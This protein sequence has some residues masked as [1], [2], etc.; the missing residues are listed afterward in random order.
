MEQAKLS[1]KFLS[2]LTEKYPN[3][4][5]LAEKLADLLMIEKVSIYRRLRGEIPF[6]LNETGIIAKEMDLSLD[7]VLNLPHPEDFLF[8]NLVLPLYNQ[9][10][11]N[12][13]PELVTFTKKV[14]NMV[15][16]PGESELSL[17]YNWLPSIFY[18]NYKC[19]M[20]FYVFKLR[21]RYN[22]TNQNVIINTFDKL[23]DEDDMMVNL[24]MALFKTIVQYKSITCIW[25]PSVVRAIVNDI[26]YF[27]TIHLLSEEDMAMLK[28]ELLEL[29]TVSETAAAM[30]KL[31]ETGS[32]FDLYL[33]NLDIDTSILCAATPTEWASMVSTF[34]FQGAISYEEIAYHKMKEWISYL[35][36]F[37]VLVSVAGERE[38]IEF[39]DRQRKIVE[40][41]L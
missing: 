41:T 27:Y 2:A 13:Y 24:Q 33:S 16:H 29:L 7:A 14:E 30:G 23:K 1:K 26:K 21:Y 12:D 18:Y 17:A 25:D 22:E 34:G 39:F 15:K 40:E 4:A 19:L 10:H 3:K 11:G 36:R 6:T 35:K 32:K 28:Q 9:F 31:K 5:S 38:R 37:S 8:V 20:K